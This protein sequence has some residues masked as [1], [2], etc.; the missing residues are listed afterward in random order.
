VFIA[1]RVGRAGYTICDGF[2]FSLR[3]IF[4]GS[5]CSSKMAGEFSRTRIGSSRHFLSL[6]NRCRLGL[7]QRLRACA[8]E[9]ETQHLWRGNPYPGM[10]PIADQSSI[11][12]NKPRL[13]SNLFITCLQFPYAEHRTMA[14]LKISEASIQQQEI[15][16]PSNNIILVG[17]Q[18]NSQ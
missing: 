5:G 2:A 12:S 13:P 9:R 6:F 16:F 18:H 8:G 15:Q 14:V 17:L 7:L 10:T 3:S 11:K 4:F 1:C